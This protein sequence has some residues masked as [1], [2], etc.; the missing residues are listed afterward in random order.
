[1]SLNLA[2]LGREKEVKEEN[3]L[4][5]EE[6]SQIIEQIKEEMRTKPFLAL[7]LQYHSFQKIIE[8]VIEQDLVNQ[9]GLN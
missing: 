8:L 2:T 6:I 3:E 9:D 7:S 1:M 4:K 5:K